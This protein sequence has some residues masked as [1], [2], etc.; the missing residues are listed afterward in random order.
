MLHSGMHQMNEW[1][2]YWGAC[3]VLRGS[4][5]GW[6]HLENGFAAMLLRLYEL[7]SAEVLPQPLSSY[8]T[9]ILRNIFLEAQSCKISLFVQVGCFPLLYGFVFLLLGTCLLIFSLV[10]TGLL[11]PC[12]QMDSSLLSQRVSLVSLAGILSPLRERNLGAAKRETNLFLIWLLPLLQF[13]CLF[14]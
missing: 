6:T 5:Q 9:Y 2:R 13:S 1:V 10:E 3:S 7:G 8:L 12:V 11:C 4:N 14:H